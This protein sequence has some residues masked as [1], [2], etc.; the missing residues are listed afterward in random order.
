[1]Q[2]KGKGKRMGETPPVDARRPLRFFV[3]AR[4][5][6]PTSPSSALAS[7]AGMAVVVVRCGMMIEVIGASFFRHWILIFFIIFDALMYDDA[8]RGGGSEARSSFLAPQ[9]VGSSG[10]EVDTGCIYVHTYICFC[11]PSIDF[12]ISIIMIISSWFA[13]FDLDIHLRAMAKKMCVI[14]IVS[15][16]H[17]GRVAAAAPEKIASTSSD[18]SPANPFGKGRSHDPLSVSIFEMVLLP[19]RGSPVRISIDHLTILAT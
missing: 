16:C 9:I 19:S 18:E 4:A 14:I 15:V 10:G 12:S 11:R 8:M 17:M 2:W 6:G 7:F 1:M 13:P 3:A 5:G